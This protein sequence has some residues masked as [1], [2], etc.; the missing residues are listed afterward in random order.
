MLLRG[1]VASASR[2]MLYFPNWVVGWHE[3]F[4]PV[5][6]GSLLHFNTSRCMLLWY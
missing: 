6:G 4:S 3:L 5:V 1:S 2:S